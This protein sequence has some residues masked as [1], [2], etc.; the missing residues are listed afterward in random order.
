[1]GT[2]H[3]KKKYARRAFIMVPLLLAILIIILFRMLPTKKDALQ[4]FGSGQQ[5]S[6]VACHGTPAGFSVFHDPDSIG[7]TPCHLGD[8]N[9][10]QKEDAH[11]GMVSLP[12]N[13]DEAVMTCGSIGCH[14][15]IALR[16]QNSLMTTASG[17][18]SVDRFVFGESDQLSVLSDIREIGHTPADKHLRNLCARCHLGKVKEHF[19]PVGELTRGGGCNACHLNYSDEALEELHRSSKPDNDEPYLIRAHP[20]LDLDITDGHCFGCHSRSGRIS[21]NY[22]G[23]HETLLDE[24]DVLHRTGYRLLEDKRVLQYIAEDVHHQGGLACIDCHLSFE[25]MGDG[26]KYFHKEQQLIVQCTDCHF[27]GHVAT[28]PAANLD[29]ESGKIFAIRNMDAFTDAVLP[30]RK[31]GLGIV[32]AF[33]DDSGKAVL[34]T[35]KTGKILS[36]APPQPVCYATQAHASLTCES[37]HTRWTPQC[38]GCHN[39][40]DPGQKGYDLLDDLETD[41][42]W[43]EYIGRFIAEEPALGIRMEHDDSGRPEDRVVTVTPGMVLS[44][45]KSG[46]LVDTGDP[47]FHRLYAPVSAH[48]ISRKGRTCKS[49]HNDPLALGYGRGEMNYI[50]AGKE[51]RWEFKP[52]FAPNVNDGLPEDAWIGFLKY[53]TGHVSTRSDIRPFTLKEQQRILF[54]GA[55]LTCHE[56]NDDVMVDAL[57]DFNAVLGKKSERCV[58]PKW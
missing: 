25:I 16:I 33:F 39:A 36:L 9:A 17:I 51:G 38:I 42:T 27:T 35:K 50:I 37:C 29:Y 23:W 47:L 2:E 22:G 49:C 20:S 13:L 43:V 5:E 58:L 30:A 28:V 32:N 15:G 41:G 34:R 8:P 19:G 18:V 21:L 55:C 57:Y 56:E 3:G 12:G 24:K 31:R 6:C 54:V 7:C 11:A 52:R 26:N 14:P 44:I 4:V 53:R 45:D 40:Y 48:T 46:L 1:M 10:G